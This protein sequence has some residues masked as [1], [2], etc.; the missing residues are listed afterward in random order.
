MTGKLLQCSGVCGTAAQLSRSSHVLS[1]A[2]MTMTN[3]VHIY[4]GL[5]ATVVSGISYFI[6]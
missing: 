4:H 2:E 5:R 1:R 6:S 3:E